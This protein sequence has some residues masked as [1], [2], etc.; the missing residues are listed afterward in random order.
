MQRH[1]S[2]KLF[3][4]IDDKEVGKSAVRRY[5]EVSYETAYSDT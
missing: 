5:E 4:K 2:D 3:I 1:M